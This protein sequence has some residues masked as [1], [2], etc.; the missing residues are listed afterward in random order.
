MRSDVISNFKKLSGRAAGCVFLLCLLLASGCATSRD[1]TTGLNFEI[2]DGSEKAWHCDGDNT[3]TRNAFY[4]RY[5]GSS[6]GDSRINMIIQF[7]GTFYTWRSSTTYLILFPFSFNGTGD[8]GDLCKNFRNKFVSVDFFYNNLEFDTG[9]VYVLKNGRQIFG[10]DVT[11]PH[12]E[13]GL[14]NLADP[15]VASKR[16]IIDLP[17]QH[18]NGNANF[19]FG[20]PL[21]CA[22]YEDAVFVMDGLYRNGEKLP[23]LKIK[24]KYKDFDKVPKNTLLDS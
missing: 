17:E 15:E 10:S 2:L 5:G 16:P 22:D 7:V 23:P 6:D 3:T 14:Y 24:L 13:S 1:F 21:S 4:V 12:M 20:F 8:N 18:R 11:R 19:W 9:R